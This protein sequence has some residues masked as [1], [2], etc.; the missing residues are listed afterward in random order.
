MA[1]LVCVT[2]LADGSGLISVA[3]W[4]P[5]QA[6]PLPTVL[7]GLLGASL[8]LAALIGLAAVAL[9]TPLV[10]TADYLNR[11]PGAERDEHPTTLP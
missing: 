7:V 8:R 2:A 1:T 4:L 10:I 6:G 5:P 11:R 9:F 3:L